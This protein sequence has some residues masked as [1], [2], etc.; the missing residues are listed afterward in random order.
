MK[1][2]TGSRGIAL[3][4]GVR[5]G[6]VVN[7]TPRPLYLGNDPVPIVQEAGWAPWTVW[8]GAENLAPTVMWSPDRP[9]HSESLYRLSFAGPLLFYKASCKEVNTFIWNLGVRDRWWSFWMGRDSSV[10]I[11]TRYE[12]DGTGIESRWG[13]DFPLPSR[14]ALGPT[15]PPVPGHARG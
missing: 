9:A 12:L 1:A 11:A 5:W 4:F 7:A 14:T 3:L 8:T 15:Q 2:Q 13:R 10:G 6:W